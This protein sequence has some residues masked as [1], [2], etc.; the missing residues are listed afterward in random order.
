[1]STLEARIWV[2]YWEGAAEEPSRLERSRLLKEEGEVVVAGTEGGTLLPG[3][4]LPAE[5]LRPS[6]CIHASGGTP[7]PED[8]VPSLDAS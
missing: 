4:A 1:M 5:P 2:G 8:S 6:I 3:E 7:V